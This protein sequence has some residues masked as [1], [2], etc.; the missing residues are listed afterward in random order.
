[1]YEVTFRPAALRALRKLPTT[2]S[3]RF[4]T[5]I[6]RLKIN[7]RPH[8]AT[9]LAGQLSIYRIR[10]GDYRILYEIQDKQLLVIVIDLGH[11]REIYR[12]F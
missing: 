1:M 11:R 5:E 12:E 8:G 6:E 3:T 10:V 7:P 9:K 4:I 2:I